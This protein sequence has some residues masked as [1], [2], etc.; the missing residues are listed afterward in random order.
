MS[1]AKPWFEIALALVAQRT[2]VVL[3]TVTHVLGSAPR[4]A[5]ARMI[6]WANGQAGTVGGGNLEFMIVREAE[7][8]LETGI[9]SKESEY[10]LGPIL[11]QCCGGRVSV[12]IERLDRSHKAWLKREARAEE[13]AKTPLLVFGAGHVGKAIARAAA[14][15]PFALSLFDTRP[16]YARKAT[17][18]RDPRT[19]VAAAPQSAFY[20]IV[21]HNHDLD[22]EITRS[23]LERGDAAYVGLIGSASKR[24][25]FERQL[26]A[27]AVAPALIENLVCPI[28]G[29][30]AV[31]DKSPP[32][33]AACVVAEMLIVRQETRQHAPEAADVG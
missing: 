3:V 16:D 28:G 33:I 7:A 17:L 32:A 13:A 18:I 5:G 11:G 29:A 21:T 30:F 1:K 27:D 31:R 23:V 15:L 14:P 12:R 10:P 24:A 26:R 6:V 4:E 2:P 8:M 20:L 25:R 9:D 19:I 22:Y